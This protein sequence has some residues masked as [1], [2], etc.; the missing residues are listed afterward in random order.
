MALPKKPHRLLP[1]HPPAP[2]GVARVI[3]PGIVIYILF[4]TLFGFFF[5]FT[6]EM[7]RELAQTKEIVIDLN[8]SHEA[9]LLLHDGVMG[10]PGGTSG[11]SLSARAKARL[12][13][14]LIEIGAVALGLCAALAYHRPLILYF[15]RK[16]RG[17]ACTEEIVATAKA[18]IWASPSVMAAATAVPIVAEVGIRFA[19]EG[20]GRAEAIMVP[21][22]IVILALSTLFTYLWQRHRIQNRSIP[23]L[24]SPR[25]LASALPGGHRLPVRRNFLVVVTLATILPISL[26][27][28]FVAPGVR[29][30]GPLSSLSP[31]QRQ[32][33]FG[34][35]GSSL[36]SISVQG[37]ESHRASG[38]SL[39]DI[40][41]PLI[42]AFDT[43]RIVI[44][45]SLGLSL[46]LVY[47]FFIS[48]WTATDIARPIEVLRANMSRVEAGD[49]TA[50]TPATSAN[51]IGE[52]TVGF[53]SM[54]KGIAE[55]GRIK[56]LF[57]QYLTKEISEAILE[58]RVNMNGARYEASVMFTD[59]R[60][61]TA[62]SERLEPEE[63]FAF[64]NDYLGRMI[65]VIVARGGIIDKFLG[66]GILAVFGL[67]VPSSTHADDAFAA[68]MDMRLALAS[69]NEERAASGREKVRIGIGIHTGDVIAGNV[70]SEKKLQYTV[71]G[72]TVNLAS[73]IEGLNKDFGSYLLISGATYGRLSEAS[74]AAPLERISG[75]LI[76]GKSDSVD[77]YRLMGPN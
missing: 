40:P 58:G 70:G 34:A 20:L 26:V 63:V 28:L 53:N 4:S 60:G 62:M 47:V 59:I 9:P 65:E 44:G 66:D 49:L 35:G 22:E 25:E 55:R 23:L 64:L 21:I 37:L 61:F 42:G 11:P 19:I 10:F 5:V 73:R 54:L 17:E 76:R 39:S 29:T 38:L 50:F 24:F 68:A 75:A 2:F 3:V 6:D 69:L 77:L 43:L 7:Q 15:R 36:P 51:E 8:E 74:L 56:E 27:V 45:L 12:G 57:G 14:G 13:V 18:R 33:L 48:R 72:D 67:P 16:R 30:A 46:V 71:I 32:L 52:L 1:L 41:V 31:D